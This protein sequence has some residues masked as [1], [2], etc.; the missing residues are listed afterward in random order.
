MPESINTRQLLRTLSRWI[1]HNLGPSV[2]AQA[3]TL[4]V[5]CR[6]GHEIALPL[7]ADCEIAEPETFTPTESQKC[8]LIALR[9]NGELKT[10]ALADKSG[11]S[12][13]QLFEKGRGM[14]QLREA[15]LVSHVPRSGYHLTEEGERVAALLS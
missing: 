8:I 14:D 6:N 1:S 9:E 5:R 4:T 13:S 3:D 12:K 2:R 7:P 15:G 10:D 11:L